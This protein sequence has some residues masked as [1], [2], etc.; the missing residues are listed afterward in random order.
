ML[1]NK[2]KAERAIFL[3]PLLLRSAPRWF[4]LV[5]WPYCQNQVFFWLSTLS[6]HISNS[7]FKNTGLRDCLF[8]HKWHDVN[9]V[10]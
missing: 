6:L 8:A 7:Q 1:E 2:M 4:L 9:T 10:F 3:S 5:A